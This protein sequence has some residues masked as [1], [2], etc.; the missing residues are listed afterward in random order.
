MKIIET[1]ISGLYVLEPVIHEDQRGCFLELYNS[2]SFKEIGISNNFVQENLSKSSYQFSTYFLENYI[3]TYAQK[4]AH[5]SF[6]TFV[7]YT[8]LP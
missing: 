5:P 4:M 2:K 3:N 7:I 8:F 6:R 1:P